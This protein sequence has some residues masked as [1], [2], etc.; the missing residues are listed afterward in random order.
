MVLRVGVRIVISRDGGKR[1]HLYGEGVLE[2]CVGRVR[3]YRHA[4][5]V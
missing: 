4:L 3:L 5:L 1:E 2:G